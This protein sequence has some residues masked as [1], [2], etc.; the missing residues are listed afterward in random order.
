M[1]STGIY[2]DHIPAVLL[3]HLYTLQGDNGRVSFLVGAVEGDLGL[4]RILLQLVK[5]TSAEGIGTHKRRLVALFLVVVCVFRARRGLSAT[6]QPY[7]HD[8]VGLAL[9]YLQLPR[10]RGAAVQDGT[11]LIKDSLLNDALLVQACCQLLQIHPVLDT[12]PQA[13]DLLHVHIR[14]QQRRAD[15]LQ[16]GIQHLPVDDRLLADVG[17][18]LGEAAPQLVQHHGAACVEL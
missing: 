1:P 18:R 3:E 9:L 7:E 14:L 4:G 16:E 11:Q 15:L 17:Q 8:N 2:N 5:C 13:H 12:I 10:L 6:L